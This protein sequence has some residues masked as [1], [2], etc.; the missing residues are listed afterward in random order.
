LALTTGVGIVGRA[1]TS[2]PVATVTDLAYIVDLLAN[3]VI[4]QAEKDGEFT[5]AANQRKIAAQL[6]VLIADVARFT[7]SEMFATTDLSAPNNLVAAYLAGTFAHSVFDTI[8]AL[9]L[10]SA[11]ATIE[12]D[13]NN[14]IT[15]D[16]RGV[17]V[18]AT[19]KNDVSTS[20][21]NAVADYPVVG[22][23][24]ISVV[25]TAVTNL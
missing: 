23:G 8:S 9:S 19:L 15:A 5:S 6:G 21:A 7:G 12:T 13:I 11:T 24:D 2:A 16:V 10:G 14:D 3:G 22:V 17:V 25:E 18:G 20:V 1:T 4:T